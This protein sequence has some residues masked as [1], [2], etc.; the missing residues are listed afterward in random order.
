ME[1]S[2]KASWNSRDWQIRLYIFSALLDIIITWTCI[3]E[4]ACLEKQ[5]SS[6]SGCIRRGKIPLSKTKS[7]EG[8]F[9]TTFSNLSTNRSKRSIRAFTD[10]LQSDSF[11]INFTFFPF[12]L[13]ELLE[14]VKVGVAC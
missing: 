8:S 1:L 14:K 9:S 13:C 4:S 11:G 7:L 12:I 3:D 2:R 10:I 6:F 5:A